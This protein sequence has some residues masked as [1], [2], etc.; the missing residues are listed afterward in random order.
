MKRWAFGG[1][2]LTLLLG[3]VAMPVLAQS[4]AGMRL[5][6]FTSGS[7]GGFPK[8]ALQIGGQGNIDWAPVSFYVIKHPKGNVMFDTGNND[9]TITNADGWWGP[10][11]KGFGLKMTQ[12]DAMAAQLA[13]IGL[14]TSDIKYVV[15]G[16][17]HLDHGGNVSQFPNGTLVV[18]NDEMKAAW[19]PDPGY[20]IYYIPGDFADTKKMNVIRLEADLD[21]FGDRSVEIRR[22]PGH[23]PG[24]QFAV[25]RLPKTGTVILTSDVVYLKESLE[26]NLIPPIPGTWSPMAMY[27]SYQKLRLVRDGERASIFYG[28][29]PEVFKATK[30]APDYYE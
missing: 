4:P 13:K 19:W 26:K 24:S 6:V 22:A 14:K 16:H 5:Y 15:V 20:S 12:N 25:V 18:Q 27:D 1:L 28:H 2:L 23:T 29:D 9:K 10:L 11:A 30:Q 3:L 8:A 7:L 17:M 21:L